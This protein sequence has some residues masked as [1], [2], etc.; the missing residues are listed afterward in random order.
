MP[1]SR[2]DCSWMRL[3]LALGD[4]GLGRTWPN[5][6]VGCIIVSGNRA[7]ARGRTGSGGRPHAESV[8]LGR[9]KGSLAGATAY[10][11]LEPCSHTGKTG[12]CAEL[13]ARSGI[14]RVVTAI[15]DPDERVAG[16]GH[17]LLEN[18]GVTVQTGCLGEE[19]VR[20]HLGFLLRTLGNRPMVT[21]KLAHSLDGSAATAAGESKWISGP[22]SRR[23]VHVMRL[24]HD[25][26]LVGKGTA[27]SDDPRLTPR[28]TGDDHVPVRIVLDTTLSTSPDSRLGRSAGSGPV[29]LCHGDTASPTRQDA[30][31][32]T[33]AE[34]IECVTSEGGGLDLRDVMARLAARG[35]TRV[36][37]EGGPTLAASLVEAGLVDRIAGFSAG[38]VLGS[39][40]RS[41]IGPIDCH[42][43]ADA[44]RFVLHHQRRVGD[45]VLTVWSRPV[46]SYGFEDRV[47][48]C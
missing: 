31:R 15:V 1:F 7:I 26:V 42:R 46:R 23:L 6:S 33:G 17:R 25:A 32:V 48:F 5:P 2:L 43:I 11:S 38:L 18:A 45:D 47:L 16:T 37:C 29:W 14:G 22:A 3:A 34:T 13:L 30:W 4:R 9:V 36:L 10:L 21:L 12:P 27:V 41:M 39:E 19:A 8:A 28:D 44:P 20:S 24:R 35:I 40:S